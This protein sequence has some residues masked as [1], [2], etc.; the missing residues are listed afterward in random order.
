M[1][2]SNPHPHGQIWATGHIP[3]VPALE[4]ERL[5][6]YRAQHGSC[7]LCDYLQLEL[8]WGERVVFTNASFTAVVPFWAVWPF[9]TLVLS[10]RHVGSLVDLTGAQRNDLAGLL[11]HLTRRYDS[12]FHSPFPFS[13]GFHQQ[14]T[15]ERPH[16]D[17]HLHAHFFPPLLRSASVRK[18][19][20]GYELLCEPQR[21]IT[22]EAAAQL[23]QGQHAAPLGS[24]P[25]V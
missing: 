4:L 3:S 24:G 7:L 17:A 22:P 8:E 1:G 23:L 25:L 20:V 5:S 9:E 21:D 18:Y 19:M 14:T 11:S 16:D 12:L 13:M 15:D 2:A 6:E 10:R